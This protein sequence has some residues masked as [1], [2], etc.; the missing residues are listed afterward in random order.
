MAEFK[1]TQ[2][3]RLGRGVEILRVEDLPSKILDQLGPTDFRFMV[4]RPNARTGPFLIDDEM[5][6]I[7]EEFR[8][9][10]TMAG[11][12]RRYAQRCDR[13]PVEILEEIYSTLKLLV[14]RRFLLPTSESDREA[15]TVAAL[16]SGDRVDDLE[17]LAGDPSPLLLRTG[18]LEGLPYLLLEW[19]AGTDV[20]DMASEWRRLEANGARSRILATCVEIASIYANLHERGVIHG[21]VNSR[22]LLVDAQHRITV[23][24]FEYARRTRSATGAPADLS[25]GGVPFLLEPEVARAELAGEQPP[26]ATEEGEQY[27]IA[28][29]LYQLISGVPYLDFD[30]RWE[31]LLQQIVEEPPLPLAARGLSPWPQVEAVL[32]RALSKNPTDR[33][34]SVGELADALR[35][36]TPSAPLT[37]K[38]PDSHSGTRDL[39]NDIVSMAAVD[40]PWM[41]EESSLSSR[42]SVYDGKA[43][44]ALALFRLSRLT[45]E[46]AILEL[47]STWIRLAME[48]AKDDKDS[49]DSSLFEGAAGVALVEALV[50]EAEPN[51]DRLRAALLGLESRLQSPPA[52]LRISA[53]KTSTRSG[54]FSSANLPSPRLAAI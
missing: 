11:S 33:F 26:P 9:P 31:V 24:D 19:R 2:R 22:N 21:D 28:A 35:S 18:S 39:V 38:R 12:L 45:G 50:A 32:G 53:G 46:T 15:R 48:S 36:I 42:A 51:P 44:V 29:L 8:Q 10:S 54:G 16:T 4:V 41:S 14:E 6:A 5:A 17:S 1:S 25:R 30:L 3:Y 49:S 40:G 27:S 34:Q 13:D 47:S 52:T 20:Q 7:L 23:L 37:S 43:G